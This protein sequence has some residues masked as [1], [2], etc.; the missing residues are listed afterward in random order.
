MEW[1]SLDAVYINVN[2]N[3]GQNIS[4]SIVRGRAIF[5]LKQFSSGHYQGKMLFVSWAR[6]YKKE[7]IF[8]VSYSYSIRFMSYG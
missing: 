8:E 4:F 6:S 2:V 1:Q 3:F 7:P 5:T